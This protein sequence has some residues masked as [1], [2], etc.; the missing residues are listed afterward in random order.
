MPAV[1]SPFEA[2]LK[3]LF[4]RVIAAVGSIIAVYAVLLAARASTTRSRSQQDNSLDRLVVQTDPDLHGQ[5]ALRGRSS[6]TASTCW[7]WSRR[8]IRSARGAASASTS[9]S[10][11]SARS[12]TSTANSALSIY[13]RVKGGFDGSPEVV[14]AFQ[15]FATGTDLFTQAGAGPPNMLA[16]PLFL[17][18]QTTD[19]RSAG[20]RRHRQGAV[21]VRDDRRRRSPRCARSASR[22]STPTSTTTRA[23]TGYKYFPLFMLFVIVL[24]WLLYRSFRALFAFVL[25]LGVCAALDRRLRRRHR[26]HL[27]ASCRRWC[28]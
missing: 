1:I 12:R 9:W 16:L 18:V 14:A 24:N 7:C 27:H 21:A 3:R 23:R 4:L 22:T 2:K 6:A 17:D 20:H 10:R 5:Q 11:R 28:R 13:K 15:K 19:E 25:T 26:R 8:A